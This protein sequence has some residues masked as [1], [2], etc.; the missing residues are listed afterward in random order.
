MARVKRPDENMQHFTRGKNGKHPPTS[1]R[2]RPAPIRG[3]VG[4]GSLADQKARHSIP[5][6][7]KKKKKKGG[8][9]G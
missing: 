9:H 3:G 6:I 4:K 5:K 8:E 1:E 2:R 7:K